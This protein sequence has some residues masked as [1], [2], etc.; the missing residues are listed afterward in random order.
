MRI[1][2]DLDD[3]LVTSLPHYVAAFNQRFGVR[4]EPADAA[5]R[6]FRRFPQIPRRELHEFFADLIRAGFFS[7]R[8][9]IPG[10]REAVERLV[11]AGHDLFIVTGRAAQDEAITRA[12]LEQEGL[13]QHFSAMVHDGMEPIGRYKTAAALALR[14]DLFIEDELPV[15][16]AVA[17]AAAPV[18]LY[19][20]PWN[21]GRLPPGVRRVGSW[22]EILV[23]IAEL[24][25]RDQSWCSV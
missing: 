23:R 7:S 11:Q 24:E 16:I 14:L 9:L 22:G 3:V 8:P 19:D 6:M 15:A 2:L 1:G 21:Q 18:L 20:H 12:W 13:T 17:Q 10:A 5:W 4:V 25:G